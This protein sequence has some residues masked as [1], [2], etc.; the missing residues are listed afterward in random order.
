VRRLGL[1]L[2]V[3]DGGGSLP[4]FV[5]GVWFLL[6]VSAIGELLVVVVGCLGMVVVVGGDDCEGVAGV[7]GSLRRLGV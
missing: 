2:A 1:S 5:A 3:V 6:G 7:V 4:T